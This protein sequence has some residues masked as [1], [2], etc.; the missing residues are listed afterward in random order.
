MSDPEINQTLASPNTKKTSSRLHCV[1]A[2]RTRMNQN[3]IMAVQR[4]NIPH[5]TSMEVAQLQ[6]DFFFWNYYL[7]SMFSITFLF[8]HTVTLNHLY[9]ACTVEPLYAG[10][11]GYGS[12]LVSGSPGF[13]LYQGETD[14]N[15]GS[16]GLQGGPVVGGFCCVLPLYNEV[17]LIY[18]LFIL[19]L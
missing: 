10:V 15:M 7:N 4:R 8:I 18:T 14:G 13:S 17:H 11:L 9:E 19:N 5:C 6:F 3:A 1:R 12:C 16:R 2:P